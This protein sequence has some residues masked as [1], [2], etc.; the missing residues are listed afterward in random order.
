MLHQESFIETSR[1]NCGNSSREARASI[2]IA[3]TKM[4]SKLKFKKGSGDIMKRGK[5]FMVLILAVS[6]LLPTGAAIGAPSYTSEVYVGKKI[7]GIDIPLYVIKT[8]PDNIGLK[9]LIVAKNNCGNLFSPAKNKTL[10]GINGGYWATKDE[11]GAPKFYL[12][13]IAVENGRSVMPYGYGG[14]GNTG[15]ALNTIVYDAAAKKVFM[16]KYKKSSEIEKDLKKPIKTWWA[17]SGGNA[18]YL[19]KQIKWEETYRTIPSYDKRYNYGQEI[20]RSG[21]IYGKQGSEYKIWLIGTSVGCT[22]SEF[23]QAILNYEKTKKSYAVDFV[24]GIILDGGYVSQMRIS[25]GK[26]YPEDTSKARPT[27]QVIYLKNI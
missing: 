23:R 7:N 8:S 19:E 21:I 24:D 1:G 2:L 22:A 4:T 9:S 16:E 17:Q 25:G 6:L 18:L 27:P 5:L 26:Q 12:Y 14:T 3:W 20:R 15:D 13:S 11:P 10:L